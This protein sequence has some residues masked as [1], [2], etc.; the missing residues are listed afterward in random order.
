MDAGWVFRLASMP[1]KRTQAERGE[2]VMHSAFVKRLVFACI[3]IASIAGP[4][5]AQVTTGTV[6]GTLKDLQGGVLPG[7]TV[8]L[9]SEARGTKMVP[10]TTNAQGDFVIPNVSPDTYRIEVSMAGFKTL[11]RGGLA[12][13]TGDR[14][15]LPAMVLEV[16]GATETVNVRPTLQLIQA[17]SGE[18]SFTISHGPG[19]EP[20]GQQPRQQPGLH[21][22]CGI[23]AG[24]RRHGPSRR[25][26]PEQRHDGRR[27][28]DGHRQQPAHPVP[29]HRSRR[30]GESP[31]LRLP[32]R[33]RPVERSSDH[34][35]HQERHQRFHGSIY[36][37]MRNSDW[38]TNS[39]QNQRNGDPKTMNKE[40][41][42]GYTIGGPMG[43]PG[44]DN[45]LFFFFSQEWRPRETSARR[46]PVPVPY[47]RSSATATSRRRS[48]R[49][50][51]RSPTSVTPRP[52][53][54]VIRATT[55]IARL[56]PGSGV[57]RPDRSGTAVPDRAEPAE[58]VPDAH[59][60]ARGA[61]CARCRLQLRGGRSGHKT[62]QQPARHPSGLLSRLQTLRTTVKYAGEMQ[63]QQHLRGDASR[64][65]RH[66]GAAP[67]HHDDLGDGE[68]HAQ[69]DDLRRRHLRHH[70][71]RGRRL[72]DAQRHLPRAPST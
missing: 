31:D 37:V 1:L 15:P 24:C 5:T 4:A 20:P 11:T 44:G 16:G 17:Q 14:I 38:N 21:R 48:I 23:C 63:R 10:V 53:S 60:D 62:A 25:R 68:L 33:V 50:A 64:L 52:A 46:S 51:R 27:V 28:H 70:A 49:T 35:G 6:V 12:V 61:D 41:D 34:R 57:G 72:H 42:W 55:V 32:G 22:A 7:A 26:R 43:K 67:A 40:S 13:G 54:L 36:D 19:A 56:L 9:V 8:V 45:K 66:D 58:A 59:H 39:W 69:P 71:E 65:Q 29:Q 2:T 47:G 3:V 18:R 30:R